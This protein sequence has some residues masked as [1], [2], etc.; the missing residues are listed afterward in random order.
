M[1]QQKQ[2]RLGIAAAGLVWG[3]FSFQ[4]ANATVI[5]TD[6]SVVDMVPGISQFTTDGA[7]MVG[8]SVT[9]NFLGGATETVFWTATGAQSGAAVGTGWSVTED[10]DTFNTNAW[11]ADF[12]NLQVESLQFN[13]T[14]GLTLF[15]RSLAPLPGIP[16][17]AEG[18]DF[19]STLLND[20]DVVAA[21]S[22]VVGI[23]A[24]PPVGDIFH[25]LTISFADLE[26]SVL[27]GRF[28]FTQDTDNDIRILLPESAMLT[29]FGLGLA[30]LTMVLRRRPA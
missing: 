18:R 16:G 30:G 13:A 28:Q 12:G 11:T 24:I 3:L 9:V 17:S 20:G 4:T 10:G 14:T 1:K 29:I 26:N 25:T 27:S 23:G 15:D 21:Y 6:V 2:R 19:V 22:N 8:M 7:D 5:T